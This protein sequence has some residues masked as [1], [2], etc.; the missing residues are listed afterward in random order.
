MKGDKRDEPEIDESL[1]TEGQKEEL[2]K[3]PSAK[4]FLIFAGVVVALIA[5]CLV[6]MAQNGGIR[7]EPSPLF[8]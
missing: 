8:L 3:K 1:L 2:S 7:F 5:I 6:L 4:G